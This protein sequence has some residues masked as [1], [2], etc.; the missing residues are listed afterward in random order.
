MGSTKLHHDHYRALSSQE[1]QKM[2]TSRK[3]PGSSQQ[4]NNGQEFQW[5]G[6]LYPD[7]SGL[8]GGERGERN[9][10]EE[11]EERQPAMMVLLLRLLGPSPDQLQLPPP[12]LPR[13]LRLRAAT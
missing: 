7:L 9:S 3:N 10:G 12:L 6:G 13:R 5:Q 11:R 8:F 4:N 2:C 1:R